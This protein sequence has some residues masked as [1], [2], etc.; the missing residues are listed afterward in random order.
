M[1]P[2]ASLT[3]SLG[4]RK[5]TA[6]TYDVLT[7]TTTARDAIMER[8][9]YD[10]I[11]ASMDLAGAEGELHDTPGREHILREA[12]E[13]LQAEYR[14]I[15]LDCPPGLGLLTLNALTAAGEVYIPLQAEYLGLAGL[16][17][18]L[19]TV[20]LV[21]RRLNPSLAIGG[22]VITRY[23]GRRRL[24]REIID[25]I[26]ERFPGV[27]FEQVIRENIS[28]AE[29]PGFGQDVMQYKADSAGAQDYTALAQ[30]IIA[31]ESR[32]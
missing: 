7:G 21:R 29:A 2:Q 12:L 32:P 6:T 11:P 24:N 26:R 9:G 22:I 25:S 20:E 17:H 14:Y 19:D 4:I 5:P 31:R 30:E 16:A 23:D 28:I 27:L 10:V 1:D 18:L 13:P 8:E 3:A 15:F